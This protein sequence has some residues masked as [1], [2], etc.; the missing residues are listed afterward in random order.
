M[1][2]HESLI[3]KCYESTVVFL[4]L[5]SPPAVSLSFMIFYESLSLMSLR[6]QQ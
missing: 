6:I 5:M 2:P 1:S 3:L 4:S